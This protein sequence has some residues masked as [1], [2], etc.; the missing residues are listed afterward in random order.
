MDACWKADPSARPSAPAIVQEVAAMQS[1]PVIPA[2]TWDDSVVTEIWS[3]IEHSANVN[4]PPEPSKPLQ[5]GH[6]DHPSGTNGATSPHIQ[7]IRDQRRTQRAFSPARSDA[8]SEEIRSPKP[9][10]LAR[11][12]NEHDPGEPR[13]QSSA[14]SGSDV[15]DS[16]AS[17][18]SS[19]LMR[20]FPKRIFVVK[21]DSEDVF[22]RSVESGMWSGGSLDEELERAARTSLE[23]FLIFA[24]EKG[25]EFWGYAKYDALLSQFPSTHRESRLAGNS[26]RH[27][28]SPWV[29]VPPKVINEEPPLPRDEDPTQER[30]EP[31]IASSPTSPKSMDHDETP[32]APTPKVHYVEERH[33]A[34][35]ELGDQHEKW[36]MPTV[37]YQYS[38]D[39]AMEQL[40]GSLQTIYDEENLLGHPEDEMES[41]SIPGGG[42]AASH[43]VDEQLAVEFDLDWICTERLPYSRT[44]HL[45]NPWNHSR[46]VRT[47]KDGHELEPGVGQ[48]LIDEW[49][50]YA[51]KRRAGNR[52]LPR[53]RRTE[54]LASSVDFTRGSEHH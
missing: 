9:L 41:S 50:R 42:F 31:S 35:G 46:E 23:V 22:V 38:L 30:L 21:S 5:N 4:E 43:A 8:D 52:G 17:T 29:S 25:K 18:S 12:L 27:R 36:L 54:S 32:Q 45:R 11:L 37:P 39:A 15:S 7:W 53:R 3:N 33:T 13:S 16:Y 14:S 24:V 6:T 26:G 1:V 51:A 10:S 47:S 28:P 20:Y 34:P 2:S 48:Q 40:V 49:Q 44:F 19:V